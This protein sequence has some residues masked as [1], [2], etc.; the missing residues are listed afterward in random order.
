MGTYP[1]Y[2]K[3][4]GYRNCPHCGKSFKARGLGTH[5]RE[6]HK[7]L[8]K[9]IDTTVVSNLE[10]IV[11]PAVIDNSNHPDTKVKPITME[12]SAI[13]RTDLSECK[14]ADGFHLYTDQDLWILLGRINRVILS[15]DTSNL[16]SKWDTEN[17]CQDLIHDFEQRF[18][19][20]FGDVRKVNQNINPGKTD[21]E[22]GE[23]ASRYA[24]LK[25]SRAGGF[26]QENWTK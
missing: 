17:I 2:R 16:L 12:L 18:E 25:Y 23:I 19:C 11:K 24:H 7:M 15:S 22:N 26:L 20:K 4:S 3:P 5:I 21:I 9:T 10:A 6:A 8:Y 13:T 14:R 1:T